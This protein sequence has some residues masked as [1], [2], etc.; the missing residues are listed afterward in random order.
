MLGRDAM[1]SFCYY[2]D[3]LIGAGIIGI[4]SLPRGDLSLC[5]INVH[6]MLCFIIAFAMTCYMIV[7]LTY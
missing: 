3:V 2:L 6:G 5:I 1:I 4:C 7:Y